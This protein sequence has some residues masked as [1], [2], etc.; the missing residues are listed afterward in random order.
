MKRFIASFLA[1]ACLILYALPY[2]IGGLTVV[3]QRVDNEHLPESVLMLVGSVLMMGAALFV[4]MSV[5]KWAAI[6]VTAA[7][8]FFCAVAFLG[9]PWK[10]DGA[11]ALGKLYEPVPGYCVLYPILVSAAFILL[12]AAMYCK[13]KRV[14]LTL[15]ALSAASMI[16]GTV[17]QFEIYNHITGHPTPVAFLIPGAFALAALC[18]GLFCCFEKGNE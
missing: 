5:K 2:L 15:A 1:G 12:A 11:S 8:P 14:A 17:F 6:A 10:T 4:F 7:V 3:T 18:V 13:R 9:Y 16:G